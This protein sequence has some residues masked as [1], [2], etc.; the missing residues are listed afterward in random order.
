MASSLAWANLS[1]KERDHWIHG[2]KFSE[3]IVNSLEISTSQTGKSP[4]LIGKSCK[5]SVSMGHLS[6]AILV[7]HGVNRYIIRQKKD[8]LKDVY[9]YIVTSRL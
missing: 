6:I 5:S 8:E 1:N 2:P 4:F 7:S 3:K 9:I